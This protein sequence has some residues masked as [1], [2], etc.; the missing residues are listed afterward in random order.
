M[1]QLEL[2]YDKK[3]KIRSIGIR[4]WKDELHYNRCEPTPYIALDTLFKHYTPLKD[5]QLVDFGCGRGRVAFYIHERFDIDTTG[6]EAGDDTFDELLINHHAYQAHFKDK[7]EVIRFEYGLAEN[8]DVLKEDNLFYFFNPFS[9]KIFKEVMENIQASYKK[10]PRIMDVIVYYPMPAYE[11]YMR[12]T[13]F[14][15]INR[16]VVPNQSD[17]LRRFTIYRL[18]PND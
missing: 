18:K 4:E 3:L 13:D 2:D 14:E 6:V 10:H 7:Q 16:I 5:A 1:K 12:T 8:Y 11:H 9:I 17:N 15:I